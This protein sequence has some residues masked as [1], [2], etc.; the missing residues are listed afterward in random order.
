MLPGTDVDRHARDSLGRPGVAVSA[1]EP[2]SEASQR[3][4]RLVL[5]PTTGTL[6]AGRAL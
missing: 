4:Q 2:G 6:P 5:D 1:S 3:T